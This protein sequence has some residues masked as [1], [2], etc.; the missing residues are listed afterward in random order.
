[1][2]KPAKPPPRGRGRPPGKKPFPAAPATAAFARRLRAARLAAGLSQV[3]AAR[4]AG[5]PQPHWSAYER[6]KKSP[7]LD[8]A[9]RLAA[10]VG[11]TLPALVK[12]KSGVPSRAALAENGNSTR[13]SRENY[14]RR[15]RRRRRRLRA[16]P[17]RA[18]NQ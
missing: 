17:G 5:I 13:K 4:R 1:M 3:E 2:P 10:A 8:Q 15:K 6:G 11:T 7:G 9:A 14:E 12:S 16:I 18:E